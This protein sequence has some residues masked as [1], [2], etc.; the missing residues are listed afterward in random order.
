MSKCPFIPRSEAIYYATWEGA[1]KVALLIDE[2]T[3]PDPKELVLAAMKMMNSD[4]LLDMYLK[5]SESIFRGLKN[6]FKEHDTVHIGGVHQSAVV[7]VE[8]TVKEGDQL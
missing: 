6:K 7:E 2:L 8:I 5:L 3:D 1:P 4:Q